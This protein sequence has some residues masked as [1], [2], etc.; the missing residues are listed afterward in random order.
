[1]LHW[2]PVK[3]LNESLL[4]HV[5]KKMLI[6]FIFFNVLNDCSKFMHIAHV[7]DNVY[8]LPSF[9][10]GGQWMEVGLVV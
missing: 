2:N 1:M 8:V 10:V 7:V 6:L 3:R 5:F 4:H 9:P